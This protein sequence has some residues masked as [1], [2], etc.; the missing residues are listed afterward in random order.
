MPIP[1]TSYGYELEIAD[2]AGLDDI[3]VCC[4]NDMN[5]TEIPE[6]GIDYRC[7]TCGTELD[8]DAGGLVFDIREKTAA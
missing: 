5:G 8:I 2:D 4:G 7:G 3:P 6:G 1:T